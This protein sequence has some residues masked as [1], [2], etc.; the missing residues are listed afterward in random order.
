MAFSG[1][2]LFSC[3]SVSALNGQGVFQLIH[4]VFEVY[5]F[6][7]TYVMNR[8]TYVSG[9]VLNCSL[10]RVQPGC[11]QV[12]QGDLPD[13]FGIAVGVREIALVQPSP[14]R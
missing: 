13:T 6:T 14:K 11:E 1:R 2:D 9:Q 5:L 4:A 7:L 12:G 3:C 10:N 8:L